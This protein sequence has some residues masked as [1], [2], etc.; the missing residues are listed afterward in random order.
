MKVKDLS[1]ENMVHVSS[2]GVEFLQFR[3]LLEYRDKI[4]HAYSLKPLDFKIGDL[5]SV[6]EDYTKLCRVL[7]V[8]SDNIYRPSQTHSNNV[9]AV[10]FETPRY[11]HK[12]FSG[13]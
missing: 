12:R 1:N 3:R 10:N 8:S 6:L 7:N 9:K 5:G 13:N 11:I 2:G 4:I